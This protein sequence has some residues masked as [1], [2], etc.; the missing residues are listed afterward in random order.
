[1]RC[2]LYVTTVFFWALLVLGCTQDSSHEGVLARVNGQPIYLDEV[3]SAQ[4]ADYFHWSGRMPPDLQQI[5]SSYGKV[6]LDQIVQKLIEQELNSSGHAVD[7]G[8][9]EKKEQEIRQDYPD[10]G[11]EEVLIQEHI[12]LDFWRTR[13]VQNL[14]WDKFKK[15]ILSPKISLDAKEVM[16]YYHKHIE[17]FY[18]PERIVFLHF[19]SQEEGKL[20]EVLEGFQANE[21]ISLIRE[22]YPRI[23]VGEYEMR[24][25]RLPM[26][27]QDELTSLQENEKS[28]VSRS[29]QG[30]YHWVMVLERKDS[31]LLKPY[32]VYSVIEENL[33]QEKLR[34]VFYEWLEASVD[35]SKIEINAKLL[36]VS[37][38]AD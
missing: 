14:M 3:E 10:G 30:L 26:E 19:S 5:K 27:L 31:K 23:N 4:D 35:Q 24:V 33:M 6:L 16:A 18:I 15:E 28:Q 13:V 21:D 37:L 17:D 2:T 38:S 20:K 11:F 34:Q 36:E 22:K 12:D 25:D 7:P 8:E 32:Q 1:M 29:R 9:L